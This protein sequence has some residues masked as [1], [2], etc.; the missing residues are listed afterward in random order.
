MYRTFN[1]G[2]GMVIATKEVDIDRVLGILGEAQV[3]G[4]IENGTGVEHSAVI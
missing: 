2:M 1:M 3:I 4:R